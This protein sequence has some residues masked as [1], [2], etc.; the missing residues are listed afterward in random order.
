MMKMVMIILSM[1]VMMMIELKTIHTVSNI[2]PH[3]RNMHEALH[4]MRL[5]IEKSE[6]D[7][8]QELNL[9]PCASVLCNVL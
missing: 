6:G 3:T 5:K 8:C 4:V 7:S 2:L 9:G 1:I